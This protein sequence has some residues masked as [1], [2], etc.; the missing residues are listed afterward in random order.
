MWVNNQGRYPTGSEP[1]RPESQS[2]NHYT[3]LNHSTD[4]TFCRAF[5]STKE[6]ICVCVLALQHCCSK[7]LISVHVQWWTVLR[8][9]KQ[10]GR[11]NYC[12]STVRMSWYQRYSSRLWL[13]MCA[14][15]FTLCLQICRF[16]YCVICEIDTH[17][18]SL[19]VWQRPLSPAHSH[20]RRRVHIASRQCRIRRQILQLAVAGAFLAATVCGGQRGVDKYVIGGQEFRMTYCMTE[21]VV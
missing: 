20:W 6:Y 4:R 1:S 13:P 10:H 2:V 16:M 15:F 7:L 3:R 11:C 17:W 14:R 19:I 5:A 8:L 12:W 18:L 21:Y 9:Y